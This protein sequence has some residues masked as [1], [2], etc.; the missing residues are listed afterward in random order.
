ML[1]A[2]RMSLSIESPT[3]ATASGGSC[4]DSKPK[5]K[6]EGVARGKKVLIADTAVAD[7]LSFPTFD[8]RYRQAE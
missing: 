5:A 8:G 1:V 3:T 2:G 7:S 6:M 4:K